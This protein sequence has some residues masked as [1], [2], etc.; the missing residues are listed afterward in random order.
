MQVTM[1]AAGLLGFLLVALSVRVIALRRSA[2][3]SL[4]DGGNPALAAR[5]RAQ[6]NFTEY[7]PVGL[8]L[9]FLAEQA[10]GA[11]LDVVLLA[12]VFVAGR[13]LHPFGLGRP[14]PNA[15]RL[16]GMMATFVALV[17]LAAIVLWA[18]FSR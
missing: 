4:G 9:I 6:G 7:A 17:A 8:I 14:A 13:I 18:G 2:L 16:V 15:P 3:V 10:H 12:A 5:I 1:I 11:R